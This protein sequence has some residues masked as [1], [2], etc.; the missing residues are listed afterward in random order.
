MNRRILVPTDDSN[1][2]MVAVH[3]GRA[4]FF[5]VIDLD[6]KGAVV[7][8]TVQPNRGEHA[9]GRGHAHNNVLKLNPDVV[10][11]SGMGPRG[12][13]SFQSQNIAVLKANSQSVDDIIRAYNENKLE[14]LTEG[15]AQAHH[16]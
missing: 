1:G 3:F 4:P 15:C 2:A 13:M 14:E 10:V 16:K 11:V 6:E 7:E 8:R 9:G 5:T 12:L